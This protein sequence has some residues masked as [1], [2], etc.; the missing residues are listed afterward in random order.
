MWEEV[1]ELGA[2]IRS[3]QAKWED[4]DLD[5]VDTRL[6]WSG[7]FHRRKRTPGKFMMR[8]KVRAARI[9]LRI[10]ILV[11]GNSP[12]KESQASTVLGIRISTPQGFHC[13]KR[14]PG[15]FTMH[16]KVLSA[17]ACALSRCKCAPCE[18]AMRSCYRSHV[19]SVFPRLKL[20]AT[21][22]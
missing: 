2:L 4:L 11:G 3:G 6:K 8:L 5:D 13:R 15:K 16:L 20:Q 10:A 19:F 14:T 12:I 1:A 7:L 21:S 9:E 22:S 18:L 17:R